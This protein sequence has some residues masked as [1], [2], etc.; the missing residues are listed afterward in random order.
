M[1]VYLRRFKKTDECDG[2][3]CEAPIAGPPEGMGPVIP[4]VSGDRFD[5]IFGVGW[6]AVPN[7]VRTKKYKVKSKRKR[8]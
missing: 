6:S 1:A 7:M 5:N 2:A 8:K 4:G 3:A